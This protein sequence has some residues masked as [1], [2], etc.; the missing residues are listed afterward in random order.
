MGICK[1]GGVGVKTKLEKGDYLKLVG[2]FT[3]VEQQLKDQDI[4]VGTIAS[5]LEID[6]EDREYDFITDAVYCNETPNQL[7]KKLKIE[8]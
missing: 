5:L 7:L 8:K 2:L 3:I 6:K 1:I 4:T